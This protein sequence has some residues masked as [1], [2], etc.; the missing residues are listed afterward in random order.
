MPAAFSSGVR[1]ASASAATV[2]RSNTS[3]GE[4]T[5]P[6]LRARV[7]SWMETMLSPPRAKKSSSTPTDA[8]PRT[9]VKTRHRAS[10]RSPPG[11]RDPSE[12]PNTGAGSAA[13]S[14]LPL[15]VNGSASR[16][17]TAAGTM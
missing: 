5:R 13:R 2:R 14:S 7:T 12:P 15:T 17:T 6:S 8:S 11:A 16:T 1:A 9:S 10:S 3:R 4:S